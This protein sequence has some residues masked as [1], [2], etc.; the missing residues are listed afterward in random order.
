RIHNGV[1]EPD[2]L[3]R[4][5]LVSTLSNARAL[6]ARAE[7]VAS[8]T[9]GMTDFRRRTD[10]RARVGRAWARWRELGIRTNANVIDADDIDQRPEVSRILDWCIRQMCPDSDQTACV[11]NH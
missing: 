11:G 8:W 7:V 9:V 5:C 2:L 6:L 1:V 3:I 4:P 10:A